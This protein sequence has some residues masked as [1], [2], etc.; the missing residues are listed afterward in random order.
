MKRMLTIAL[1]VIL[2]IVLTSGLVACGSSPESVLE[3]ALRINTS[4]PA[5]NGKASFDISLVC[6]VTD[7]T[8]LGEAGD[9]LKDPIK[10]SFEMFYAIEPTVALD[11]DLNLTL[12]NKDVNLCV[13]MPDTKHAY[14]SLG[15]NWYEIPAESMEGAFEDVELSAALETVEAINKETSDIV[16]KTGVKPS[17]WLKDLVDEGEETIAE[18]K[19][20][21]ISGV[22]DFD[23]I[24]Q[25]VIKIIKSDK[26]G[27]DF[28][29][30]VAEMNSD[31]ENDKDLA[32]GM[33]ILGHMLPQMFK[34]TKIDI[35]VSKTDFDIV[36]ISGCIKIDIPALFASELGLKSIT[37]DGSCIV[38][39]SDP[40]TK[41]NA[42][43][44]AKSMEELEK[45]LVNNP[46]MLGPLAPLMDAYT[47]SNQIIEQNNEKIIEHNKE[48]LDGTISR[49]SGGLHTFAEQNQFFIQLEGK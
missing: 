10:L 21:H 25:D 28:A 48:A 12:L 11:L 27:D 4:T 46:D 22:P 7:A 32:F 31:L 18:T 29:D 47:P 36:K 43:D 24:K 23:Y 35:W 2:T 33:S 34:D 41:V 39:E 30:L 37:L 16:K 1:T 38:L 8:K 13:K 14:F 45:D 3:K 6:D 15:D 19:T 17:K 9:Y 49:G 20:Y 42:P 5:T 44:S 26:L 40:S